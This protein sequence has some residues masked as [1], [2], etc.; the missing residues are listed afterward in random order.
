MLDA[1]SRLEIS[2]AAE[3]VELKDYWKSWT[4]KP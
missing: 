1:A 2:P 3:V 4:E